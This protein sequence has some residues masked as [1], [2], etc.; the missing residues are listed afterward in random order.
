MN[1]SSHVINY[2][3]IV[4]VSAAMLLLFACNPAPD[5]TEKP[6]QLANPASSYCVSLGGEL[7]IE[8]QTEGEVGYCTLPSGEKIEEWRLY[9]RDHP[10]DNANSEVNSELIKPQ[11]GKPNPATQNCIA[12]GGSIDLA[13]SICTLPSG[14]KIEQ[15]K[16]Y[17][18]DNKVS[19]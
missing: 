19:E 14:E 3:K 11:V 1:S 2:A 5:D 17:R 6:V 9:R 13:T 15:W 12:Q 4:T 10:S 16:L 8:K 18:R 7:K